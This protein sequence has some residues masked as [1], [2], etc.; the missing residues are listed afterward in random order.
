MDHVESMHREPYFR[1]DSHAE[2]PTVQQRD[3]IL[4]LIEQLGVVLSALRNLILGRTADPTEIQEELAAV[5]GKA[6]FDMEMLRGFDGATL[7]MF[8]SQTGEI[9]PAR[10]WIMAELLY[11]DGMQALAEERHGDGRTSLA[12]AALLFGL[13]EPGGGMLVGLPEAAD[14]LKEIEAALDAG[15]EPP[16]GWP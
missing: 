11:M 5:A 13:I 6:G 10:C 2:A 1:L 12:K 8:V 16:V 9:E 14:R 3:Y 4:R 15:D 7:H